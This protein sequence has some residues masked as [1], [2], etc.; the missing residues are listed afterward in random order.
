MRPFIGFESRVSFTNMIT[1][2]QAVVWPL[3]VIVLTFIYR[4]EIPQLIKAIGGKMS[5]LSAV[6]VTVEFAAARPVPIVV[7]GSIVINQGVTS[8]SDTSTFTITPSPTVLKLAPTSGLTLGAGTAGSLSLSTNNP[9]SAPLPVTVKSSNGNVV[10]LGTGT[11]ATTSQTVTIPASTSSTPAVATDAVSAISAG[12]ATISATATGATAATPMSVTVTAAPPPPPKAAVFRGSS[13]DA[14]SFAFSTSNTWSAID[15]KP[16]TRLRR[17]LPCLSPSMAMAN[18][19]ARLRLAST[20]SL[21]M[22][23]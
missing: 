4:R 16:A 23:T 9:L 13:V 10:K 17:T 22:L 21:S 1:L 15:T 8:V 2:I 18:S 6:G 3:V 12:S 14:Q 19:F 7:A 5:K 20:P 11:T